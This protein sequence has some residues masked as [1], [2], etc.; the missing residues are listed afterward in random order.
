[1]K[2]S[3]ASHWGSLALD[4]IHPKEKSR[5]TVY[6]TRRLKLLDTCVT[7][8]DPN[9]MQTDMVQILEK[10][11]SGGLGVVKT[12]RAIGDGD[13]PSMGDKVKVKFKGML[14]DG[15]V[16]ATSYSQLNPLAEAEITLGMRQLYGT[17]MDA[18]I[19]TM[20]I[21]E[22]AM[23]SV[24]PEFAYGDEG[25]ADAP[26]KPIPAHARL[27]FDV[28]LVAMVDRRVSEILRGLMLGLL[29]FGGM[30]LLFWQQGVF[31]TR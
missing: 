6:H 3:A 17:G 28:E 27:T 5:E 8:T 9:V 22:R 16:F 31:T 19:V 7:G 15:T 26:L 14:D 13:R 4:I 1:M 11:P 23:I 21:G 25:W 24:S 18:G 30:M 20:R 29:A 2:I 12:I 10:T